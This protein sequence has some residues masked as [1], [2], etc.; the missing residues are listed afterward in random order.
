MCATEEFIEK[1]KKYHHKY[2]QSSKG[3]LQFN[4]INLMEIYDRYYNLKGVLY[5]P[6]IVDKIIIM[7]K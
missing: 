5:L 3:I 4:A 1:I 6:C 2:S 7:L